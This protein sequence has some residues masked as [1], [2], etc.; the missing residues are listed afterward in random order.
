MAEPEGAGGIPFYS[1]VLTWGYPL[2][3]M[4]GRWEL[5]KTE[6]GGKATERLWDLLDWDFLPVLY[7][8]LT[9]CLSL[10]FNFKSS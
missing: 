1:G 9:V 4:E 8:D 3:F 5:M 2:H 7:L 6:V 10:E